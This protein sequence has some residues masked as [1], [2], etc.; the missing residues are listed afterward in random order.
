MNERFVIGRYVERDSWLHQLDP[1][2]KLA[3]I[4]LFMGVVFLIHSYFGVLIALLFVLL[5]IWSSGIPLRQFARAIRP[6]LFLMVFIFLFH[7]LFDPQGSRIASVGSVALYAGG[8]E[9]GVVAASRMALFIAFA[10]LISFTTQP[11]RLAQG[12]GSL[13]KPLR[14]V[15]LKTD[16]FV[17]MLRVALRFL[18]TIFDEAQRLWKAQQSRGL[19]FSNRPLRERAK[20][21][22]AL[23]VPVATAVLR[24]SAVLADSMEARGYQIDKPRT[25]YRLLEW[26]ARDTLFL[27]SFLAPLA[28]VY[29]I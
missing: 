17:L 10:A 3:A 20:L 12:L 6:L 11:D 25:A 19:S 9:K 27:V 18:P 15:G 22:I 28:A 4:P 5:M 13:L 7:L 26:A 14:A 2:A 24:R 21:V 23:L 8:L 16:R 1:R 29:L